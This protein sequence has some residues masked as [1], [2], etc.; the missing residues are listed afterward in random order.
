MIC[1]SGELLYP[2]GELA[3]CRFLGPASCLVHLD[4]L[5][6]PQ[7]MLMH[8]EEH[9]PL[10]L[11]VWILEAGL[12]VSPGSATSWLGDLGQVT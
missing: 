5:Q 12:D 3:K 2:A 9:K 1:F 7:R 8:F 6:A 10:P 4:S 11:R